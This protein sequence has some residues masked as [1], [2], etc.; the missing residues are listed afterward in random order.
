MYMT[1]GYILVNMLFFVVASSYEATNL[2]K[3]V[4]NYTN[5]F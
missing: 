5:I 2:L 1:L 3:F 4:Q